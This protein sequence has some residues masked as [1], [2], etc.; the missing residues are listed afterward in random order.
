VYT[1]PAFRRRGYGTAV[2]AHATANALA[3]GAEHVVL[4]TDLAN[5]TSNSIYQKI[6]FVPDHD[7]EERAFR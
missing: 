3:H 2:T 1:P 6:G 4:Y 5:P 7:A